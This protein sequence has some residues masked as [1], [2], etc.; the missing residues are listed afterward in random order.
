[1]SSTNHPKFDGKTEQVNKINEYMLRA[2]VVVKPTREHYLPILEF[3]YNNSKHTSRGYI[4]F[5]VDV[6]LSAKSPNDVN[7]MTSWEVHKSFSKIYGRK[8]GKGTIHS[9]HNIYKKKKK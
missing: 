2:Y 1:M 6:C 5:Y 4:P 8:V 3:A 9:H 7:I